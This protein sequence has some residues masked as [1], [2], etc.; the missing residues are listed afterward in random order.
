MN[1][2]PNDQRT[3]LRVQEY[4]NRLLQLAHQERTL[5]QDAEL[6][7]LDAADSGIARERLEAH[8]AVEAV[9]T[10][11]RRVETDVEL[12]QARIDR[13]RAREATVT[14]AKDAE[15]LEHEIA[16]LQSRR[17]LLEDA[18]LEL[19]ER[20][21]AAEAVLGEIDG[22]AAERADA[23]SVLT[24][25]RLNRL[26]DITRERAEVEADRRA[27]AA[28]V[29]P[30]LLAVFEQK[31]ARGS[32]P[33]GLLRQKTCGACSIMLTGTDLE[34]VRQQP[35]DTVVMC[36]ECDAILVRTEESGL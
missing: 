20:L 22:R 3:L 26:A 5:P 34:R 13:D 24:A 33:V 23:R 12:V 18:E 11:L 19:M 36:P 7:A 27:V 16:S 2:H 15:G 14:S 28:T 30:E 10:E 25:A 29:A 31:G 17:A 35:A 6:D 8:E 32:V 4:D 1:A 9:R 21:E